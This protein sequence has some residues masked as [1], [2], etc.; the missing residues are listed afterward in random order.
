MNC[1]QNQKLAEVKGLLFN[2]SDVLSFALG[3][4]RRCELVAHSRKCSV[5][6]VRYYTELLQPVVVANNIKFAKY[7]N[8][9][10][11]LQFGTWRSWLRHCATSRRVAGSIPGVVIQIFLFFIFFSITS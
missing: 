1:E 3:K 8:V 7:S 11:L 5:L 4:L 6:T 10:S 9:T 2:S